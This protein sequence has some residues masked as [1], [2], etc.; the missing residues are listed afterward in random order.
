MKHGERGA[1][2]AEFA[3]VAPLLIFLVFGIVDLGRAFY[4]YVV[5]TNAVREGARYGSRF[6]DDR[7]AEI[8][9]IVLTE[10]DRSGASGV[11]TSSS[12]TD[13]TVN[14]AS[15]STGYEIRFRVS[16]DINLLTPLFED[17][18]IGNQAAMKIIGL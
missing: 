10:I 8:Q 18:T 17:W 14:K 4:G 1:N 3:L 13:P 16:C 15:D 12:C 9:A 11:L 5:I 6:T 7:E 2:L